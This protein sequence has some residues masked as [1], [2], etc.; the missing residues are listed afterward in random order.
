MY[1]WIESTC[2]AFTYPV[3]NVNGISAT[4]GK[5]GIIYMHAKYTCCENKQK[6][7]HLAPHG[8]LSRGGNGNE[9]E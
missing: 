8:S 2:R 7:A 4:L 1:K 3:L 9:W 5:T 6:N